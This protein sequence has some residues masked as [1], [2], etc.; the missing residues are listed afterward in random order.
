MAFLLL[1]LAARAL[2]LQALQQELMAARDQLRIQSTRPRSALSRGVSPKPSRISRALSA[3]A[4]GALM[5][6]DADVDG[7]AK[8]GSGSGSRRGSSAAAVLAEQDWQQVVRDP[9]LSGRRWPA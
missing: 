2:E 1:Q 9:G 7:G 5:P 8:R 6:L 4:P 3:A